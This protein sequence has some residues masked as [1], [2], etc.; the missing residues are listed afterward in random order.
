MNT[1]VSIQK[2]SSHR[3]QRVTGQR[4]TGQQSQRP[5]VIAVSSHRTY[6]EWCINIGVNYIST[7]T[8]VGGSKPL[9]VSR[10]MYSLPIT[11]RINCGQELFGKKL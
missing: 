2:F 4:V 5:A 8:G 9:T 7:D 1:E 3:G 10:R 11:Q 6:T